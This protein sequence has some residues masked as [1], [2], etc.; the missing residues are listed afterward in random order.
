MA[1]PNARHVCSC[2]MSWEL[3]LRS[4]HALQK[5]Y[6]VLL[7]K[8]CGMLCNEELEGSKFHCRHVFKRTEKLEQP[9]WPCVALPG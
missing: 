2:L 6:M 1:I 5:Y 7:T 8:V 4:D 9:L 3:W